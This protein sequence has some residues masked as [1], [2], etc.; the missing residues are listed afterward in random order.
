MIR[1]P[2]GGG[3]E[4]LA[5]V[6]LARYL[7]VRRGERVT[8]ESWSHALPWALPFVVEARRRGAET[9]LVLEDEET[10]FRSLPF[11]RS[12]A[13]PAPA[14]VAGRPGAHVHF[15]GPEAFPRLLGLPARD[16]E[17]VMGYPH[18][19][20]GRR[21][22]RPEFRG[23]R[24]A[25]ADVTSAAAARYR[26]DLADWH[27]EVL[28]ASLVDPA[29]LAR[30]GRALVARL[31]R[32]RRVTVR[33]ANGTRLSLVLERGSAVV[34]DGRV[35]RRRSAGGGR[36]SRVPA[37]L[38]SVRLADGGAAGVWESN[39]PVYD[40]FADPPVLVG[41]RFEFANGTLREYAFD[42]GGDAFEAAY[43][44]GGHGRNRP[45]AL[46]IGLNPAIDRAPELEALS[47]RTVGLLLGD[48]RS[49]GG[50]RRSRFRFLSTLWGARLELDG[51]P[52]WN[53][54]RIGTAS[55]SAR[56]PRSP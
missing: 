55:P 27:R 8:I 4:A 40:R 3:A 6:V 52:W 5:R 37:G 19:E 34:E 35:Q 13:S 38:V 22:A 51:R 44:R 14:S 15:G 11:G 18:R 47:D 33:H 39:R 21:T 32:A 31:T 10:F 7:E 9:T 36:W 41:A 26:V 54:G 50:S 53:D 45:T 1:R 29:R 28:R 56:A 30:R 43:R 17:S 12:A 46:T 20:P 2:T 48:D 16:L 23:V 25:I 42:R 24:M 49:V